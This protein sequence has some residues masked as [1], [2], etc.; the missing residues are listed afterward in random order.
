MA[1]PALNSP[2]TLVGLLL[3]SSILLYQDWQKYLIGRKDKKRMDNNYNTDE[4]MELQ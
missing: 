3:Y 2:E 4:H 1:E